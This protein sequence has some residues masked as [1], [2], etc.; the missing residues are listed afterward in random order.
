MTEYYDH[1]LDLIAQ[2]N[3]Y[4]VWLSD[5]YSGPINVRMMTLFFKSS[6]YLDTQPVIP[7]TLT[8][9]M[10][11][12]NGTILYSPTELLDI[13]NIYNF[14]G[15]QKYPMGRK[16]YEFATYYKTRPSEALILTMD[17][18]KIEYGM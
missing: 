2:Y 5:L 11:L 13:N 6:L 9:N 1:Y 10:A 7:P 3:A 16:F 14:F 8:I 12:P 17:D 15:G 4:Q 18:I